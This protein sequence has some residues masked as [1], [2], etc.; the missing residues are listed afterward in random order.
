MVTREIYWAIPGHEWMYVP[1]AVAMG[2][3]IYGMWARLHLIRLGTRGSLAASHGARI[4]ALVMDG[5]L[6]RRFWTDLYASLMHLFILW[7]M[8]TLAFGTAMVLLKADLGL[9]V[10]QGDFYLWLSLALDA[11][12]L[13]AI[14]G[15]VMGLVRRYVLRPQRLDNRA[16]DALVL[17]GLLVVFV[18]GFVLEGLR[19]AAVPDPWHAWSPVG[20]AL[21]AA[22]SGMSAG[23]LETT[24]QV[25]WWFHLLTA[26]ALIA[27]VPFTK[28][29]H[30]ATAPSNQMSAA[31]RTARGVL[32]PI[33]FTDE[34]RELYGL[35]DVAELDRRARLSLEACTRCG[36]CQDVCPA[37]ASGKALT[38]KQVILDLRRWLEDAQLKWS[39]G[40]RAKG[41]ESPSVDGAGQTHGDGSGPSSIE[42]EVIWACTTCAAC[43]Q[44]CP[45]CIEHPP[46]IVELRQFLVMMESAIPSEGQLALRNIETNYNPWGIGWAD[47]A[48]WV[49]AAAAAAADSDLAVA[50][51]PEGGAS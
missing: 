3:F 24:Y 20:W 45:V 35:G 44:A 22:F 17:S 38:P 33:D 16:E 34:T 26:C 14:V 37:Y 40:S 12:G 47:R 2:V 7:G 28:L 42:R 4:R 8:L 30:M 5:L 50:V 9:P 27:A 48:A 46:L 36:R 43:T 32:A 41:A 39:F 31:D 51:E 21:S 6:Q 25:L 13:A 19:M 18:V 23:T 49:G 15:V 1:A 29:L 10:F 11:L